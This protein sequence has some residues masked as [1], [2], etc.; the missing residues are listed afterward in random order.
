[1]PEP[2][3]ALL[4]GTVITMDAERRIIRDGA[5]AVREGRIAA[6]GETGIR[7][8]MA[9]GTGD[10]T[11]DLASNYSQIDQTS[12]YQDDPGALRD[13]L[14][15]TEEFLAEWTQRGEGRLRPW[16]NNLGVPS[17]SEERFLETQR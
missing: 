6:V 10:R 16:I 2:V 3:Y 15:R 4:E 12:S 9:R 14:A 11:T 8:A 5:V 17:C 1:M 13:D 7:C